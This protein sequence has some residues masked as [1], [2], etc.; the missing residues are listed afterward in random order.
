[1]LDYD[2]LLERVGESSRWHWI[3]LGLLWLC[4]M[5]SGVSVLVYSLAGKI[6][7]LNIKIAKSL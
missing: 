6:H 3:N 1:M 5:Y 7:L 4:S 2:A